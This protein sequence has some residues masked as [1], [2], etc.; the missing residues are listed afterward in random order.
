VATSTDD[1][2]LIR[3]SGE[4][5]IGSRPGLGQGLDEKEVTRMFTFFMTYLTDVGGV[6][7]PDLSD[8]FTR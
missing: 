1:F 5:P 7:D 8:Y 2:Y 6:V 3:G 4:T